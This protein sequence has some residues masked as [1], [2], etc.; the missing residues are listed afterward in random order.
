MDVIQ[1]A[2]RWSYPVHDGKVFC[3]RQSESIDA[4][5][6]QT[7]ADLRRDVSTAEKIVCV[8]PPGQDVVSMI[9]T[10]ARS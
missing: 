1:D 7:C 6:C 4:A 2:H 10:V 9:E 8:D 5:R 3:P